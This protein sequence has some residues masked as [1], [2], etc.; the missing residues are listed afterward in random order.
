MDGS[1]PSN[2]AFVQQDG[3]YLVLA[4]TVGGRDGAV[5][6]IMNGAV[7]LKRITRPFEFVSGGGG[8]GD[9]Q[10][11]PPAEIEV[12]GLPRSPWVEETASGDLNIYIWTTQRKLV[13]AKSRGTNAAAADGAAPPEITGA[14]EFLQSLPE[15]HK[16]VLR[17]LFRGAG[18]V[19]VAKL[20]GGFSGA[21]VLR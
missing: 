19:A 1:N 20:Q 8:G 16:A 5:D 13:R 12:R 9:Q 15:T 2:D 11:A 14:P 10:E 6:V 7:D 21:L 17:D 18:A 3:Y 4:A